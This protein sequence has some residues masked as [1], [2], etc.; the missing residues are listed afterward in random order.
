M[1]R[2][3]VR[4]AEKTGA[5]V[6]RWSSARLRFLHFFPRSTTFWRW[7]PK[8][9]HVDIYISR[10]KKSFA[11]FKSQLHFPRRARVSVTFF[12]LFAG[13]C[14]LQ[15]DEGPCRGEI[16]RYYYNTLTQKCETFYY[17]GCQGNANNFKSY[18]ECQKS[19]FRIPSK[20]PNV[21]RMHF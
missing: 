17:G 13:S 20:L 16:E 2:G 11:T 7:R 19:C 8:V 15:V 5:K 14:L 21:L 18:Q 6:S 4:K 9:R 3:E 12:D 1:W 10:R